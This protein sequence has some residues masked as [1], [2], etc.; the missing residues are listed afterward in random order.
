MPCSCDTAQEAVDAQLLRADPVQ[1]LERA[2]EHMVAA[3]EDAARALQRP[4]ILE[5]GHDAE[6]PRVAL[7]VAAD[8]A[9]LLG[10]EVAA[11][12]AGVD[13]LRTGG[14]RL[15]QGQHQRV[16]ALEHGQR[17]PLCRALPEPGQP[18]QQPDQPLDLDRGHQK[19]SLNPGGRGSPPVSLPIS[20]C[21]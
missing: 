14:H 6:Q 18:R 2:A 12:G 17:R 5:L 19:G 4:Q 8:G 3:G 7:G 20:S 13:P 21:M 9:G 15:G 11:D 1:R 16:A 10:V